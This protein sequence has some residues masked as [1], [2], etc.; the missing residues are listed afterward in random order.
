MDKEMNKDLIVAVM[1][2][3][4]SAFLWVLVGYCWSEG[5]YIYTTWFAC[6]ALCWTLLNYSITK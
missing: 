3:V 4:F 2:Q 6:L 5:Q 1:A